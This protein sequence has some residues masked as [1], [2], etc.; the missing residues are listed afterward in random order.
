VISVVDLV[1]GNTRREQKYDKVQTDIE[2]DKDQ[3]WG[4]YLSP[5]T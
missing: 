4:S 2:W 5:L 3:G 1:L